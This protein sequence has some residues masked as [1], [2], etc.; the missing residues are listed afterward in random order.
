MPR[1]WYRRMTVGASAGPAAP[2]SGT[3]AAVPA[4]GADR[5]VANARG[6]SV[7]ALIEEVLVAALPTKAG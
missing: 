2:S 4:E 5:D 6:V 3:S 7:A 1:L